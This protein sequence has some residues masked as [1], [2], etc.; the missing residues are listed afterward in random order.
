M[1]IEFVET[2]EQ[3]EQYKKNIDNHDLFVIIL[4]T[5]AKKHYICNN[6]SCLYVKDLV[7]DKKYLIA[8]NHN[9][10]IP[11]PTECNPFNDNKIYTLYKKHVIHHYGNNNVDLMG[12]MYFDTGHIIENDDSYNRYIK[13]YQSQYFN[14]ININTSM[15]IYRFIESCDELYQKF[16]KYINEQQPDGFDFFNDT[17]IP[18]LYNIEKN[19]LVV[20]QT[21]LEK[22][23]SL[24]SKRFVK[25]NTVYSEYNPYT[26]TGRPSN[27][28][29]GINF[30]AINKHDGSRETIISRFL[31]GKIITIDFES[32]HL[33]L[34]SA[35]IGYKLPDT[36]VH[37][38]FGKQYFGV[39]SLTEEQYEKS[40]QITFSFLYG[41]D[42]INDKIDFFREVDK[43]IDSMWKVA[44]VNR[45]LESPVSGR[46]I[47]LS[48]LTDMNESKA[49]NYMIQLIE[50]ESTLK[51]LKKV[52]ELMKDMKSKIIL[53]LYDSITIDLNP[54]EMERLKEIVEILEEDGKYPTRVY[55]G[56]NYGEMIKIK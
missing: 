51:K 19:G 37:E 46:R 43:Y 31:D 1:N 42:N 45:C 36:S 34:I 12:L 2:I 29:G 27:K 48:N 4:F 30:S 38:F 41:N 11:L 56:N 22:H 35:L 10:V 3:F 23:F 28:F 7:L 14:Y 50:A 47:K 8:Y 40:K 5:D 21:L 44:Q 20:D 6:V 49:F 32:Y 17:I 18:T 53:Y 33:R 55:S 26:T 39:D 16:E 52:I 54:I 9:D 15:S 25:D 13:E 24:R